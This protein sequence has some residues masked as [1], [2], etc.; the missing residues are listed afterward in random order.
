LASGENEAETRSEHRPGKALLAALLLAACAPHVPYALS[1]E[2]KARFVAFAR[3]PPAKSDAAPQIFGIEDCTLFKAVTKDG[4]IVDWRVVL[5]ADWG[6]TT[7]PKWMTGCMR[8][9]LRYDG[10]YVHVLFCARAI[11]AGGGCNIG[12]NYRSRD[13]EHH[14]E[15]S[16]DQE[17][18][19]PLPK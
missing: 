9:A 15:I 8:E 11:G 2:D 6:E 13:G 7:Y 17:S 18:W 12:G 5:S 14:W 16:Q 1:D 10:S 19:Q 3:I 4:E